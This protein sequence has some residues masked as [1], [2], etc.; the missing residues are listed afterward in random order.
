MRGTAVLVSVLALLLMAAGPRT[1]G[2]RKVSAGRNHDSRRPKLPRH[3]LP[4]IPR[5]EVEA[6]RKA[7][8]RAPREAA[9]CRTFPPASPGRMPPRAFSALTR[10]DYLQSFKHP[11]RQYSP[12][13]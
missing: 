9:L 6:A 1:L 12:P 10:P 5:E 8:P 4:Q 3:V 2:H 7:S 11:E 13:S